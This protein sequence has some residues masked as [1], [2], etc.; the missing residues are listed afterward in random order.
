M[1]ELEPQKGGG[2]GWLGKLKR[3]PGVKDVQPYGL[4]WHAALKSARDWPV[5]KRKLPR[6]LK[7]HPITPSLEDVFIRMVEGSKR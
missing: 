1:I 3:L 2:D 6:G 4:R 7:A 5:L